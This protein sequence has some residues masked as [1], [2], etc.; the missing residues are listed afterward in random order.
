MINLSRLLLTLS[1]LLGASIG[2]IAGCDN[3]GDDACIS[4]RDCTCDAEPSCSNECNGANCGYTCSNTDSCTFDCAEGGCNVSANKAGA[5]TL[6]CPGGGCQLACTGTTSCKITNCSDCT[7][8]DDS[9]A[10]GI[11]M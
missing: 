9:S 3:A 2:V 1:L 5:V 8:T 6:D 7:C 11:C 4:G 10:L